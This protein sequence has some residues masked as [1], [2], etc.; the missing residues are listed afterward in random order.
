MGF[1]RSDTTLPLAEIEVH[2]DREVEF[3]GASHDGR[4][5]AEDGGAGLGAGTH[6]GGGG[7]SASDEEFNKHFRPASQ[8]ASPMA[9]FNPIA[10]THMLACTR[11]STECMR[12]LNSTQYPGTRARALNSTQCPGESHAPYPPP[13]RAPPAE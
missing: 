5:G 1:R 4:L 10:T 12:A 2:A 11:T 7:G 8:S 9:F 13:P 6:S 3:R